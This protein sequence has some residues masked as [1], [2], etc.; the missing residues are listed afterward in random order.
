MTVATVQS[1]V[2]RVPP[3]PAVRHRILQI[4][5]GFGRSA[6]ALLNTLPFS[7]GV[8]SGNSPSISVGFSFA[9][10]EA[11]GLPVDYLRLFRRLAPAFSQGAVRRSVHL[12]DS[13]ASAAPRWSP[14]FAQAH[15]HVLLSWHGDAD[16]IRKLDLDFAC[17]WNRR[18]IGLAVPVVLDGM[19]L[20]APAKGLEGEWMH[21]GL[22]DGLSEV[23]I[24]EKHPRPHAPDQR[25]HAPG[26]LLLGEID[27]AGTNRFALSRAP[28][29]VRAFFRHSTFGILRQM[30]QDLAA[31]ESQVDA[32]TEQIQRQV[33]NAT[34]A[35][36]KA[37]L[38]GR[39]PDGR[40]LAPGQVQPTNAS[41]ALDLS[42]DTEG[43]GCPFGSHVRRMRSAP[44]A[45]N[46]Q[47]HRPLQRRGVPFGPAAWDERPAFD[48][49]RG[50][51]GH[52]F[53]ASIEDQFEHLLGQWAAK[54]PLGLPVEDSALDPLIG[55]HD[56]AGATLA[57][58]LQSRQTQRLHGFSAWTTT[59]GTM[60]AWYPA[61]C[62]LQA[63]LRDDFVR[64]EDKGPWY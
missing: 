62:G 27:D 46:H 17:E 51:L 54:P 1:L 48:K 40:Q 4:P 15:A 22:R 49:T 61:C 21:F 18:G 64:D 20:G 34:R 6:A 19:R 35:F 59:M 7:F 58:P 41:L 13:G 9:G 3:G 43:Q 24:D 56:E 2:L 39:W 8:P 11:I 50:L 12:G 5:Q 10:L 42:G 25:R 55:P 23:C 57:V 32:W 26:A 38:S 30:A 28:E 14:G 37:K 53:C 16:A 52:F 60:Y 45:L 33:P 47:F 29:K 63:L 36:V 31:F 44:D